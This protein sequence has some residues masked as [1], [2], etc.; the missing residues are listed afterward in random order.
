[1]IKE[2][3]RKKWPTTALLRHSSFRRGYIY[4][5]KFRIR[6]LIPSKLS[7]PYGPWKIFMDTRYKFSR[8]KT[9]VPDQ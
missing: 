8:M 4:I 9:A 3:G 2:T 7:M 1:M 5:S 6:N